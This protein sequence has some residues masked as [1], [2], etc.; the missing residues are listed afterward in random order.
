MHDHG[1][2]VLSA[3][4]I[5]PPP[6]SRLPPSDPR[7]KEEIRESERTLVV[8][9]DN[10]PPE[11][12]AALTA[13]G[14]S[15]KELAREPYTKASTG[16]RIVY[17]DENPVSAYVCTYRVYCCIAVCM[18]AF[19]SVSQCLVP[20]S[21]FRV[22]CVVMLPPTAVVWSWPGNV[23]GFSGVRPLVQTNRGGDRGH[24]AGVRGGNRSNRSHHV[25][26]WFSPRYAMLYMCA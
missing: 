18:H 2:A 14:R 26:F 12:G 10:S 11:S 9:Q 24:R 1:T 13:G 4:K 20:R 19:V 21:S 23:R 25:R 5:T 6:L 3:R 7:R 16:A 17:S 15:A 22:H 8:G